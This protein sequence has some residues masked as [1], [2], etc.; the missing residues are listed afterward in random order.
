MNTISLLFEGEK[1]D[2][3]ITENNSKHAIL[4]IL[5]LNIEFYYY[6]MTDPKTA[7]TRMAT[8]IILHNNLYALRSDFRFTLPSIRR[9]TTNHN[10]K[11]III[12]TIIFFLYGQVAINRLPP[13]Y[14]FTLP[15]RYISF[16]SF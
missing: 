7:T 9:G 10:I 12:V 16:T 5:P 14:Y 2:S 8:A 15:L 11:L 13:N 1:E 3:T 6:Y 4:I